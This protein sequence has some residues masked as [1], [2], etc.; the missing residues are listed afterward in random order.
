MPSPHTAPL[1]HSHIRAPP[2]VWRSTTQNR[3]CP[4]EKIAGNNEDDIVAEVSPRTPPATVT[5]TMT[6]IAMTP[7]RYR[8]QLLRAE[9]KSMINNI[10]RAMSSETGLQSVMVSLGFCQRKQDAIRTVHTLNMGALVLVE[11]QVDAKSRPWPHCSVRRK[12]TF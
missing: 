9:R 8:R 2:A 10:R 3:V 5:V 11:R 1:R 4:P 12:L 6:P 7:R